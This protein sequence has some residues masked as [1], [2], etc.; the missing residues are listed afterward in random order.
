MSQRPRTIQIF[1]PA[2]D[3]RGIRVAAL[4]TSIV[5]MIEVPRPLLSEF[6]LMPES[7]QVGVYYLIGDDEE[8]D[9]LSVYAGQTGTVGKRLNEHDLDPKRKFWNRA[10]VAVSLTHSFTPTHA[11]YLEWRSIQQANAAQRYSVENGN[12]GSKPHTPASLDADCQEFFDTIRTL[13]ST[14]GQ[15]IFEPLAV[16]REAPQGAGVPA[17][18]Q[19]NPRPQV[20]F[21]CKGPGADA[22][23]QY[24]EEGMVVLAGAR[25]RVDIVPSLVPLSPGRHRQRLIDAGDLVLDNGAYVFQRDVL[26]GSPSGASDVVLGRSSNGWRVWKDPAGKTLDELKRQKA[27]E[28]AV[29]G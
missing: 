13:V 23:G 12:A 1:L 6:L 4:T 29:L 17:V 28:S 15:P 25:G 20:L 22:T 7:R 24:T 10:L 14:L 26:F 9:Q 11:M 27:V 8:K 19:T 3:P 16:R 2:G 5:Q 21:R 18:M